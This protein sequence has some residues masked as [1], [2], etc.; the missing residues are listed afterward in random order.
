MRRY[1]I[2]AA[3]IISLLFVVSPPIQAEKYVYK[4][5]TNTSKVELVPKSWTQRYNNIQSRWEWAPPKAALTYDW[6]THQYRFIPG[7]P[8]PQ[9]D[10]TCN[11]LSCPR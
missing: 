10:S 6:T 11:G 3:I 9:S 4:Y 8:S 7:N 2:S 5:N 1:I